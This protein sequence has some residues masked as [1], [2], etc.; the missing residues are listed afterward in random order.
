MSELEGLRARD[1]DYRRLDDEFRTRAA[2][3]EQRLQARAQIRQQLDRLDVREADVQRRV[4]EIQNKLNDLAVAF[5]EEDGKGPLKE[6]MRLRQQLDAEHLELDL[7]KRARAVKTN[8][9]QDAERAVRFA[10]ELLAEVQVRR[11]ERDDHLRAEL[12][13]RV[14]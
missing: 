9:L 2:T 12:S 11:Q 13:R 1:A 10:S 8:R 14:A 4:D 3:A 7:V 6:A 5:A